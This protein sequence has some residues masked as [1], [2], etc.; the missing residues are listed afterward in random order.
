MTDQPAG[1]ERLLFEGAPPPPPHLAALGQRF[2]A[3]AAPRFRN[4][5][6]D[7]EAVQG[8]AMQSAR[9]GAIAT[10]DAQMLFLDHGDTVSLPLVQR[11]VAAH[12]TELVARWLMMLGSFH[13]PGWATPR[14]LTALDGMVACDEAALAV[15]VV[16]KHLEKTQ[17]HVRKRWRTVAAKRPKVIPPDILERYEAQLA[18]ARWE[19]PGELEA[20]RLEIAELES[21]VRAHGSPEDNLAVDAMLAELEKARKRFTGA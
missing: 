19:L 20:A 18:K 9:D 3:E 13:F 12:Q 17:A 1:F 5:R 11:Y 2:I 21:F 14:N 16:R 10:E 6:V 4:F 15:R 8:A 7:L